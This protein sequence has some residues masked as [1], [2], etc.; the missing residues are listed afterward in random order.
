MSEPAISFTLAATD[1]ELDDLKMR[2][3]RIRWPDKEPVSDWSQGV[4]LHEA[5]RLVEYWRTSYDWRRC[6]TKLNNAG[7]FKMNIDGLD[8]HFLHIRSPE[9][10]ALPLIMTHGWPGSVIEFLKVIGPLTNPVAY[11]G[12]ARDAFHLVLPS[13]PGFGFSE[14]P[15]VTGW[16]IDRIAGAWALLMQNLG[17]SRYV[18][19]GGDFGAGITTALAHMAPAGLAAIHLNLPI[20]I[21][22]E[23][24]PD[25][26]AE[27]IA[28]LAA[29]AKF[30]RWGAGYA[31]QQATRPQTLGYALADSP[32]GQAMWIYEKYWAAAHHSDNLESIVTLDE[33]LD[34][35]TS[36]WLS[37]SATSSARLYWE[38]YHDFFNERVVALPVGCS[39]FPGEFYQAP[40]RWA[41]MFYSNII[42]WNHPPRGGHFA[43]LEQPD[44]FAD[45]IRACFRSLRSSLPA[46]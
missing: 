17:Y 1:D 46:P 31:E 22:R 32:V 4:P 45:E 2:L 21:P 13:I 38:S 35:I 10:N 44:I 16:G 6:E 34:V 37:N 33:V 19:Q 18:A 20:V 15:A 40:R 26:D 9:P 5:K 11:G 27:Q 41:D 14:K 30:Q 7:Q 25:L 3:C 23:P 36:Y 29:L 39:I 12:K 8:I 43:A 28:A 24:G 42:Y